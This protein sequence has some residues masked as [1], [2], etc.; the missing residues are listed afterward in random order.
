MKKLINIR[1]AVAAACGIGAG[2]G[3]GFAYCYYGFSAAWLIPV[4][5]VTAA[6]LIIFIVKGSAKYIALTAATA[7]LLAA[8][9]FGITYKINDFNDKQLSNST[10]YLITGTVTEKGFTDSGEYIKLKDVTADGVKADGR[11]YVYLDYDYG[12]YCE[13]GYTVSFT[14]TVYHGSSFAYG[15]ISSSR[16]IEDV[17]YTVYP[18]DSLTSEYGFTVTGYVNIKIRTLLFD[19]MDSD[20]AAVAYGMLTGN[21]EYVETSTIE[22]FRYGGIAH[23]FAVSGLHIGLV[24]AAVTLIL[25]KLRVNRY[26]SAA[27]SVVLIFFYAGICGFT[28]SSVRAAIMCTVMLAVKLTGGKY[29]T[30]SAAGIAFIAIMLYNPLNILSVGFR[31][32]IAAVAG[33]ALFSGVIKR[34]L[35]RIKVPEKISS[36]ASVAAS[37]QLA[38]FP[39]LLSS[40]GYVS[41]ASLLMNIL[42]VPLLST[43]FTLLFVTVIL[44]LIFQPIAQVILLISSAP[45]SALVSLFIAIRADYALISG[46]EFGALVP[47]Y[48]AVIFLLSDK[49]NL[50]GKVRA[51]VAAAGAC[52]LC[53]AMVIANVVPSGRVKITAT[54]W[55]GD[56]SAVLFQSDEANILVICETPSSYDISMLLRQNGVNNPDAIIILGGEESI[57]AYTLCGVTC[58]DLYVNYTNIPIQPYTGTQVHYLESFDI[59]GI[60]FT[61][62]DYGNLLAGYGGITVGVNMYGDVAFLRCNLLIAESYAY[63]NYSD[64]IVYFRSVS[65]YDN[66]YDLGDLQFT[67]NN[68]KLYE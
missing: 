58:E 30:L 20:T 66:I 24:F 38:T 21:T 35:C 18:T 64:K 27:V 39:V 31:L 25:K 67:I 8:G 42:F 5:P 50:T 52:I 54:A 55:Y 15:I 65:G 9:F 43:V 46:F 12:E 53:F 32:S 26:V 44:A 22:C 59:G 62:K 23:V 10:S 13:V 11:A 14:G 61:F 40:F 28:L 36:A 68:G 1:P 47:L 17:R 33:I 45:L 48:Y 7:I 34:A 56:S 6:L 49:I 63:S 41:W 4:I 57:F 16:L 60:T 19:S 29:D 37:A 3:I 51:G 2:A